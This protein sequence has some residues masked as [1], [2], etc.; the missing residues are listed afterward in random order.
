VNDLAGTVQVR[1]ARNTPALVWFTYL[2]ILDLLTT[3][4]VLAHG[5]SEANPLVRWM[6]QVSGSA[7]AGLVAAKLVGVGLGFCCLRRNNFVL[8]ERVSTG[9]A[10]LIAWNLLMLAAANVLPG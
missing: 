2:Q 5:G 1:T 10:L 9:Y 3:L 6:M 7:V 4:A 8:L